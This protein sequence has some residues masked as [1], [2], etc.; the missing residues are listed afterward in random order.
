MPR[1]SHDPIDKLLDMAEP[2][3]ELQDITPE[4]WRRISHQENPEDSRAA[5][6]IQGWFTKWPFAA[7]FV[8]SC[9]LTGLL[10]AELRINRLEKE[11]QAQLARSYLVLIDP[12]LQEFDTESSS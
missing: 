7:L 5:L 3:P 8:A 6:L 10:L 2:P 4:V 9:I 11:Q 1:Q 12:L